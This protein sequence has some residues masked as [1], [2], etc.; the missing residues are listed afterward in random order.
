MANTSRIVGFRP[1]GHLSGG[2]LRTRKYFISSGDPTAVYP[3]DL[4]KLAGAA[5]TDGTA[6][7]VILAAAADNAVGVVA[8]FEPNRDNLNI[9]GQ[10]RVASTD[11]YCYVWDDPNIIFM[12]EVANGTPAAVDIGLNANHAV[13]TPSTTSARSGAYI[14]MGTKAT[15][16]TLGFKIIGFA[17]NIDNEVGASARVY[18]LIN[19]HQLAA[20]GQYDTG[21]T[22]VI[23]TLGT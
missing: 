18:V 22:Q 17:S 2:V 23:G 12:A 10:Y 13:G 11:R 3:G 14:D 8:W 6:A 9:T 19:K 5:D 21:A 1:V 16:S 7:T 20:G 4:V 15:T